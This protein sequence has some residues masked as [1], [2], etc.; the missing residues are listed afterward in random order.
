MESK[1]VRKLEKLETKFNKL[2]K[3]KN[4]AQKQDKKL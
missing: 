2:V 1:L 3:V 4:K